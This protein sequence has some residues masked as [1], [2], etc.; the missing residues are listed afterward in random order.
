MDDRVYLPGDRGPYESSQDMLKAEVEMQLEWVRNGRLIMHSKNL[1]DEAGYCEDDFEQEAPNMEDLCHR[2]LDILPSICQHEDS[3]RGSIL[4]HHDL[5]ASNILVDPDSYKIT[6]IVDW[7]MTCVVPSWMASAHPVFLQDIDLFTGD[8]AK[9][10]IPSYEHEHDDDID[11]DDEVAIRKR[12][13]W[14]SKYLRDHFDI[15]MKALVA[16]DQTFPAGDDWEAETKRNF[17]LM[18]WELTENMA[19]SARWLEDYHAGIGGLEGSKRQTISD[20][21][22]EKLIAERAAIEDG[23]AEKHERKVLDAN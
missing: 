11:D 7:E 15:T 22:I 4:Q 12:D 1:L 5:N 18:A 16:D 10:P 20:A 8:E 13:R 3:E 17:K 9:P 6:G 23:A 21:D 19:W 2:F 14:E